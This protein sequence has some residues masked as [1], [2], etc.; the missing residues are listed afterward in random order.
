[1]LNTTAG[2][3]LV[4]D[5]L[6]AELRDYS[7]VIDKKGMNDLLGRL[8]REQPEQYRDVMKRLSDIGARVSTESGG[9]SFGPE[10]MNK[11]VAARKIADRAKARIASIIDSP[12]FD[13]AKR[14]ALILR[15]A[16]QASQ[17]QIPAVFAEA[18]AAKNPLAMQAQAGARGNPASVNS[19]LGSDWL[20][21]DS[22][23]NPIP[24]PVTHSYSEGLHPAEYWAATYGARKGLLATKF[25]VADT[26]FLGKQLNQISHRMVVVDD[27]DPREHNPSAPRG[28]PV[29]TE[30]KDNVGALLAHDIG[31]FKRNTALTGKILDSIQRAGHSR[32]LVRSPVVGGSPDGGLY[33]RDVGVRERGTLPGRGEPVGV[34]A[35]Q[36]LAEPLSQGML[37]AKHTG[38]VAGQEKAVG[39]F[40]AINQQ[41]QVPQKLKG[42]AAHSTV[43]GRVQR[44]EDAPAGGKY[45]HIEGQRHY[46][47]RGYDVK[48][49][50]GDDVEAGDVISEG[51][52]N[53]ATI[54]EHKGIGEGRR[55]FV[56]TFVKAMKAAGMKVNRRNVEVLSRGLINHVRLTEETDDHVPD[57]VVPYGRLEHSYRPRDDARVAAPGALRDHYLEQPVL[58]YSIGTKLRPSVI[59]ELGH[60]G[61][62]EV[63]AHKEPPPFAPEMI[64]GMSNLAHDEDFITRMYGSGLKAGF[65]DAVHRGLSS[66]EA[67]TSFVPG[68][69]R[70]VDFGHVGPVRTPE[71]GKVPEDPNVKKKSPNALDLSPP[72]PAGPS[73]GGWS[74][75]FGVG[76]AAHDLAEARAMIKA[77]DPNN[78][79]GTSPKTPAAP[80]APAAPQPPAPKPQPPQP[81]AP[82][83][84]PQ[85][86]PQQPAPQPQQPAPPPQA[87]PQQ[88]AP[89]PQAPPQQPA[90]PPQ[91]PP[92]QQQQPSYYQGQIQS[93]ETDPEEFTPQQQPQ[94]QP[95]TDVFGQALQYADYAMD[96]IGNMLP[97]NSL[98]RAGMQALP[99]ASVP[100]T[101]LPE[102]GVNVARGIARFPGQAMHV[103]DPL[104]Q[105]R[106]AQSVNSYANPFHRTMTRAINPIANNPVAQRAMS[107]LGAGTKVLNK[108]VLPLDIA[109]GLYN[110][111]KGGPQ[112]FLNSSAESA[113]SQRDIFSRQA[114]KD[115]WKGNAMN[116]LGQ[117]SPYNM[118]K[119]LA[120]NYN[121][122][123]ME[124][125]MNWVDRQW[126]KA[127]GT[128]P[129]AMANKVLGTSFGKPSQYMTPGQVISQRRALEESLKKNNATP[130]QTAQGRQQLEQY[131]FDNTDPNN[132][133][134]EQKAHIA[135]QQQIQTEN[136]QADQAWQQR[137][138]REAG[139]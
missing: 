57:D 136:Q 135:K 74:H 32:I 122:Y 97:E 94:Q 82:A 51:W 45:V 60:F 18:L 50:R 35:A 52:P 76:K 17:D 15:H 54:V 120:Q 121:D 65:Q 105:T 104:G 69:A 109:S 59:K 79:L 13:A 24:L 21:A 80:A 103:L 5:A 112:E 95:P 92:Q 47:G 75:L 114:W 139:G 2:Q 27:E 25:S 55:Y 62:K 128:N 6:P 126:D 101:A 61:V 73:F 9:Y 29:N 40:E 37:S 100:I 96:P 106:L 31:G 98:F 3:I 22:T 44:V 64:R 36:A 63:A 99:M 125:G 14:R 46:V 130:E 41:I 12:A 81:P 4:N 16:G 53:P 124:P 38:G 34:T 85:A 88:P 123:V 90:P 127:V 23:D 42:G 39:G 91:A 118:G 83:P 111:I 7:R 89:P 87:P 119:G 19:L 133:S 8:A 1:M 70:A 137:L 26:G 77:A 43:D 33:S 28:L 49:K 71:P 20:Y 113:Q 102:T 115:N 11:S 117:V 138:Q 68:L 84:K 131:I 58:H 72:K 78:I 56:D 48:V 30:D 93:F 108:A 67:S 107:M 132:R 134:A 110:D 86:P 66:D 129:R 116:V 10:H